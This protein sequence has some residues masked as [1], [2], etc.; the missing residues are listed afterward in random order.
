MFYLTFYLRVMKKY[1]WSALIYHLGVVVVLLYLLEFFSLDS[2]GSRV[3]PVVAQTDYFHALIQETVDV[4]NVIRKISE[5]PGVLKI[6]LTGREEL[7]NV[8]AG[9]VDDLGISSQ[10]TEVTASS[11]QVF[12]HAGLSTKAKELIRNYLSKMAGASNVNIGPITNFYPDIPVGA[13][14]AENVWVSTAT[15]HFGSAIL[16]VFMMVLWIVWYQKV[17]QVLEIVHKFQRR[18]F[19]I[20]RVWGV[21]HGLFLLCCFPLL[22]WRGFSPN[23]CYFFWGLFGPLIFGPLAIRGLAPWLRG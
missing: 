16:L 14:R 18:Q 22:M 20:G 10:L 17:S 7:K 1:Y 23:D 3:G 9:L 6:K 8:A 21:G 4:N 19:L 5:L 11:I 2:L 15:K 13:K 12:F